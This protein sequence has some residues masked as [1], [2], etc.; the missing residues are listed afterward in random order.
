VRAAA[1]GGGRRRSASSGGDVAAWMRAALR[2]A[3]RAEARGE[4]PVGAVVVVGGTIVARAG[5]ASIATHDPTGHA[6]IRA[7]RR[8][9]RRL[10]R[11]RLVDATV[12]V[13]LEPCIMCMGALVQAR[14]AR[15]V[16]GATDP[17]VGAATVA[18]DRR[19]N[20]RFAVHGGVEREASAALLTRFFRA[21]RARARVA[22][23]SR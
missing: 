22:A 16:Y 3:Q 1:A 18:D 6:E 4:I 20:H 8:A 12:V 10:G 9:A 17:K 21:R 19:L 13:T 15:L 5:N 23:P 2:E 7:L 11:Y 14:V